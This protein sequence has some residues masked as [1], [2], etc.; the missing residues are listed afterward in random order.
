MSI[1]YEVYKNN[2]S[3]NSAY[4]K[5]FG[6]VVIKSIVDT[7][8]LAD[9]IQQNVSVK[10][11]DVYAVL[12][13]LKN[14]VRQSFDNG[15]AVRI[16]GLGIFKPTISTSCVEKAADFS[17]TNIRK[18]KIRFIPE[19]VTEPMSLTRTVDGKVVTVNTRMRIKKL[20]QGVKFTEC[21][22]YAAPETNKE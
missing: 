11:S 14:A 5:Y 17:A 4:G 19:T 20:L 22:K 3:K 8:T 10:E 15:N 1:N 6:R 18:K 9:L 13:E 16:E 7:D 21:R 12:K 2:N